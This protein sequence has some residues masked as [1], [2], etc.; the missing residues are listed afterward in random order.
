MGRENIEK[1]IRYRARWL[2][3]SLTP[4]L[5][6]FLLSPV[7]LVGC[8]ED[9][10]LASKDVTYQLDSTY[11]NSKTNILRMSSLKP[12]LYKIVLT[13]N[14]FRSSLALN[15][16]H[17]V[18]EIVTL[19]YDQ[20]K[21]YQIG[22][23][24]LT[25]NGD[26]VAHD[27]LTWEYNKGVGKGVQQ[28]SSVGNGLEMIAI[29]TDVAKFGDGGLSLTGS[30]NDY[31]IELTGCNSGYN[32]SNDPSATAT[33]AGGGVMNVYKFDQNCLAKLVSFSLDGVTFT[34]NIADG[35][36]D[37]DVLAGGVGVAE[38]A[39]AS[40]DLLPVKI[41][42][43]L[44][45]PV[46][47]TDTVSFEFNEIDGGLD[48][49]LTHATT[50]NGILSSVTGKSAPSFTIN[51]VTM[52]GMSAAGEGQFSFKLE[53]TEALVGDVCVDVDMNNITYKLIE[54][55]YNGT[56]T[57]DQ[58]RTEMLTGATAIILPDET[59]ADGN[60]GFV[61]VSLTGP[62]EIHNNPSMILIIARDGDT[63]GSYL[64]IN[65]DVTRQSN[66]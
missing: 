62:P 31:I 18:P 50:G 8:G 19:K 36:T 63:D 29:P 1:T 10:D 35:A 59:H 45:N 14:E 40:G 9:D 5:L 7:Y 65:V 51:S 2:V 60:G 28:A 42:A 56:L 47:D 30:V 39:S 16:Q 55:T 61:S 41:N 23:L 38:F 49:T 4:T 44:S 53:C 15:E 6:P 66:Q 52:T 27:T 43:Q 22:V 26:V 13:G 58:A 25:E 21:K 20:E 46:L 33:I 32:V 64:Y 3:D 37:W 57:Y 11:T 48:E 17:S 12:D 54:D 34:N 24:V